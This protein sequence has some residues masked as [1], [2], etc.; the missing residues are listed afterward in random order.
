MLE[1]VAIY[2]RISTKEG[3]QFLS[4]QL[5]A[6][7]KY[8]QGHPWRIVETVTDEHTGSVAAPGWKRII[9]LAQRRKIKRVIVWKLD[10]ITRQ[11]PSYAFSQIHLLSQAGCDLVSIQEPMFD[12]SGA[13][14]PV[15][16]AIAA[17]IA[18]Q[19][20]QTQRERVKAGLR[21][22][23][24]QGKQLGRPKL[25]FDRQKLKDLRQQGYGLDRIAKALSISR[26]SANRRIRELE[27]TPDVEP[28]HSPTRRPNETP[29]A[30]TAT[31]TNQRSQPHQNAEKTVTTGTASR[32]DQGSLAQSIH[33]TGRS[34]PATTGA[35]NRTG[36]VFAARQ[37]AAAT[38][39]QKETNKKPHA[40]P[41]DQ[42]QNRR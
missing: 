24:T 39:T 23:R 14:G 8:V 40:K 30:V 33:D 12:A 9:E 38:P 10:R 15:L 4:N 36:S 25:V 42:N 2:A 6:I 11:G 17:W 21:R 13:F 29:S 20:S 1:P 28:T 35:T 3:K 26:T 19:E 22:A 18:Q 41:Q 34:Q 27:T 31:R 16:I 32:R 5:A 37:P 7:G